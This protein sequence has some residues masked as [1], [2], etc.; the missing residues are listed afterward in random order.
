MAF[1]ASYVQ[2][3]LYQGKVMRWHDQTKIIY[4]TFQPA[5]SDAGWKTNDNSVVKDAF[6]SWQQALNNRI[7][8]AFTNDP[9][10]TDI[11]VN[12]IKN[13]YQ[14]EVG[15]Q[16][17]QIS[18]SEHIF[19]NADINLSLNNQ[20]HPFTTAEIKYMALHE[21][22]HALGIKGHSPNTND[23]MNAQMP[24]TVA[25]QYTENVALS[26]NDKATIQQLYNSKAA[27]TN[28]LGA[29]LLGYRQFLYYERLADNDYKR[30]S[31][32]Q[33][34]NKF[35]T[36]SAFYSNDTEINY[37]IGISAYFAKDYALAVRYLNKQMTLKGKRFSEA[38]L[39]LA[40]SLCFVAINDANNGNKAAAI[41]KFKQAV[42]LFQQV[43]VTK[44]VP[45]SQKQQALTMMKVAQQQL[46]TL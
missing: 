26:A 15:N 17:V 29:H 36:A 40:S 11:Q 7:K 6:L 12:W 32:K 18:S 5:K 10:L 33:A 19:T 45:S 4:V 39:Y 43:Q 42:S 21:I 34:F 20:G 41:N 35:M 16:G 44:T 23:I 2:N 9:K 25:Q 31:Y 46:A 1:G 37:F 38:Q 30:Q 8:F 3:S 27:I 28:P 13:G 24:A 22:G 14:T